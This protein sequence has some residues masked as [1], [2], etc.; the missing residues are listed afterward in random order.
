MTAFFVF[1][2]VSFVF[3][4]TSLSAATG[5]RF[6]FAQVEREGRWDPYPEVWG[7]GG[8]SSGRRRGWI[9]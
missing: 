7:W 9:L 4:P 3:F 8:A 2:G 5:D 1:L 6:V